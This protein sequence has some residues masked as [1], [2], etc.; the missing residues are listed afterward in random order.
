[1]DS[2]Y[3]NPIAGMTNGANAPWKEGV[4]EQLKTDV[5]KA[6]FSTFTS[7]KDT[8]PNSEQSAFDLIEVVKSDAYKSLCDKI[9]SAPDKD[10]RSKLKARLPA[11]TASG[12]FSK[13]SASA[14]VTHSGILIAD[15]D[16]DDNPQLTDPKKLSDVRYDLCCDPHV[17]F[18]FTSPSGGLKVG[19]CVDAT[20]AKSHKSAFKTVKKWMLDAFGLQADD[21]CSDVG[22][23]CFLSHD[24]EAFYNK[25]ATTMK[26][27]EEVVE[28]APVAHTRASGTRFDSHPER[29]Q[30]EQVELTR[31]ALKHVA[32][33]PAYGEWIK[34]IAAVVDSVGEADAIPL[35]CEWSPEENKGEYANKI[36]EGLSQISAG[37]LFNMASGFNHADA[38]EQ[39]RNDAPI[40]SAISASIDRLVENAKAKDAKKVGT[41]A[42]AFFEVGAM[43]HIHDD[44]YDR[45]NPRNP[46]LTGG[47]TIAVMSALIG[48]SFKMT[49][50][51]W[52]N[53][54]NSQVV[55]LAPSGAGKEVPLKYYSKV[56][57]DVYGCGCY[58]STYASPTVVQHPLKHYGYCFDA[59]DEAGDLLKAMKSDNSSALGQIAPMVKSLAT[60]AN[61]SYQGFSQSKLIED[62]VSYY[63][64]NPFYCGFSVATPE[65]FMDATG[66]DEIA[67]GYWGRTIL[68]NVDKVE[69][70][71]RPR[72]QKRFTTNYSKEALDVILHFKSLIAPKRAAWEAADADDE[73]QYSTEANPENVVLQHEASDYLFDQS[74]A[75]IE[76]TKQHEDHASMEPI[77][78]R[79]GE[80]ASKLLLIYT[81]S[82]YWNSD[83]VP[84]AD[85]EA[86]K[87]CWAFAVEMHEEKLRLLGLQAECDEEKIVRYA[88]E[89]CAD[90]KVLYRAALRM[91]IKRTISKSLKVAD[92]VEWIGESGE[93]NLLPATRMATSITLKQ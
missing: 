88:R 57:T 61:S 91:H 10:T 50:G 46:E 65:Q 49:N 47:A 39:I 68:L 2:T 38:L 48:Q 81:V 42:K 37:T 23:L 84:V 36:R 83:K 58:V 73:L 53:R 85:I 56:V 32:T 62:G 75:Y 55:M 76:Q 27:I 70:R 52:D 67:G 43:R 28:A 90:G 29:P 15:V 41:A 18:L 17:A 80:L 40:T 59:R 64:V 89:F 93:F 20:D 72:E 35:L 13:R 82:K 3:S 44:I 77:A 92:A 54:A 1:M 66:G 5:E 60:S 24:P 4:T 30:S 74:E 31:L 22:R 33:R 51:A 6:K 21:A 11:V 16:L 87:I 12:V 7:C 79:L 69:P 71:V 9:R 78:H 26:T 19:V 14:L 63:C 34:V 86:A 8:K 45:S 25:K